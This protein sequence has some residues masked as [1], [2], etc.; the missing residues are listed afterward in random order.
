MKILITPTSLKPDT[1]N[2]ALD[3]LKAL[4]SDLVF[5]DYGRP[6]TEAELINQIADFD[7]LIAGLDPIT[8]NVL[9][10]ATNLKVVSR[11]GAG[12]D[13]VDIPAATA[14][15]I[16]VT[17]TPGVNAQAVAELALGLMLGLARSIPHAD[18]MVKSG[19]WPRLN[20]MELQG[21]TI[22]VVG[23]GAIGRSLA[24]MCHG[25]GMKVVAYDPL[26][27]EK[28]CAEHMVDI[29]SLNDLYRVSD[30]VSLHLPHTETTHHIID[31]NAL[32]LMK[33]GALL[34]NT[35]RGGLID[36]T[37]ALVALKNGH[38]KGLALDAYEI[39]PPVVSELVLHDSVITVPHTGA[40]TA[41]AK[42]GMATLAIRNCLQV[43]KGEPCPYILN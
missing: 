1:K 29:T 36:E 17:N 18:R 43:L 7:G 4:S 15:G 25:I 28:W 5:N 32:S 30:V 10:K 27:N 24:I 2:A 16:K 37:A 19:Q 34:I 6:L 41:E 20:G 14:L 22:G 39:E 42:A 21:K 26:I 23:L 40:H 31:E 33:R 8:E 13:R 12:V 35:S 9:R 3:E 11:Y 38:L